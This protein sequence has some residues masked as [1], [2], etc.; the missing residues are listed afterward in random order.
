MEFTKHPKRLRELGE[1]W[2]KEGG[3]ALNTQ[4]ILRFMHII[5][6]IQPFCIKAIKKF[7]ATS[8]L[9]RVISKKIQM[10]R[11]IRKL[12]LKNKDHC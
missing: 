12:Q 8:L 1:H 2:G 6:Y 9:G 4:V 7:T 3:E 5:T 11:I 10:L